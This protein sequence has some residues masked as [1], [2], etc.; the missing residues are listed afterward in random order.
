MEGRILQ[1][2]PA[3][4]EELPGWQRAM[5]KQLHELHLETLEKRKP[6]TVLIQ[7]LE[8]PTGPAAVT[9]ATLTMQ[10]AYDG[11]PI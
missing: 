6:V 4:A 9:N 7:E 1:P 2:T 8:Q 5:T 11:S 10:M 3:N